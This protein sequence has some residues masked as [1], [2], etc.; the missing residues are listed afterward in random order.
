MCC[1]AEA[2]KVPVPEIRGVYK[3]PSHKYR[4]EKLK[5]AEL[6]KVIAKLKVF[7]CVFYGL[8]SQI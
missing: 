5:V 6:E 3:T 8:K 7:S 1:R 2:L 4:L